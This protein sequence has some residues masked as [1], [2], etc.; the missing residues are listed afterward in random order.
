[1]YSYFAKNKESQFPIYHI[2]K[3]CKQ[4]KTDLNEVF[5]LSQL[6]LVRKFKQMCEWE[7]KAIPGPS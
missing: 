7:W 6:S 5:D 2:L 1:M 3:F 4:D